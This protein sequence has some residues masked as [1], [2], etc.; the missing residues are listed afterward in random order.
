MHIQ[1]HKFKYLARNALENTQ[2]QANLKKIGATFTALRERAF[3][4]VEDPEK[5]RDM[6]K[7][8]KDRALRDLPRLLEML[9]ENVTKA[10]GEVHWAKDAREAN[11]IIL[12]L[13]RDKKVKSVVK[14]KSMVSEEIAIN[15]VLNKYGI[16]TWET[17]L[18]EF[19]IQL[20]GET[21]SHIVG[22]ALHKSKEEIA[23]LFSEKMGIPYTEEAEQLTMAARKALR[24]RFLK[25]DM[26]ISGANMAVAE[27]GSIVLLE[28]EGNIR[29]ST[30]LPRIHVALM[31]I[32]KVVATLDDMST[33]LSILARSASGQRMSVYTSIFTGP[34]KGG[35]LDGPEEFHLI[36]LDNGRSSIYADHEL[37]EMLRCIRCGACLNT[38]P[39]YLKVGGHSYG[40]VYSGPMG[41]VLGPMLLPN[42]L[43]RVLPFA[44]TLCGACKD[45]CPVRIDL[46]RLLLTL[47]AKFAEP[48][49]GQRGITF[50]EKVVP[51]IY[52]WLSGNP[53]L[54]HLLTKA[55]RK[56]SPVL[57]PGGKWLPLPP[58]FSRWTRKRKVPPLHPSFSQVWPELQKELKS[59][60]GST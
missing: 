36:L 41:S 21:P 32:E 38:C 57:C 52:G 40:W 58:P 39:V 55:S 10:G 54:F 25:A 1:T 33:I 26:G 6:A 15:D 50:I 11:K 22:P 48:E 44:S 49:R 7:E 31:G 42:G 60:G 35:E 2:L 14:G 16:E 53:H 24:E 3:A 29:L 51:V 59:K 28:N 18:G 45:V 8:V 43:G 47:R 19:I 4:E 20:A 30:T 9:E 17:D 5:L 27:T 12:K 23:H 56:I 34:R 13:A 37:R 46:P